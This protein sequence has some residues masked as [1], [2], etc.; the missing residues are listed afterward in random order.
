MSHLTVR[1]NQEQVGT[2]SRGADG[3][4]RFQLLPSWLANPAR[5]VLGQTFEDEPSKVWVPKEPGHVPHW[6]ANLLPERDGLVRQVLCDAW[7]VDPT[8]DGALFRILGA[9]LPGAVTVAPSGDAGSVPEAP[10]T[11][12]PPNDRPEL[13]GLKFSLAGVQLKFSV[14]HRDGKIRLPGADEVGSYILKVAVSPTQVAANEAAMMTW[15]ASAGLDVAEVQLV[16]LP[17]LPGLERVLQGAEGRALLVRRFDR[18]GARR[19][20]QEDL[21]QVFNVAPGNKYGHTTFDR[22]ARVAA[23]LLGEPGA[24]DFTRR[25]AV[26]IAQGNADA[27]LKNWS[28]RYAD[29]SAA[30]WSPMYDQVSTVAWPSVD[31][32]MALKFAGTK[33]F[34]DVD[35]ARVATFAAQARLPAPAVATAM[36]ETIA[37]LAATWRDLPARAELP[38]AHDAALREHWA[39]VPL[40]RRHGPLPP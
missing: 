26:M 36:H 19:V 16:D 2:L 27:H 40:L 38:P 12:P 6:F 24:L 30:A 8:D 32:R 37:Q 1:L 13:D 23:T 20:H 33:H 21:A 5:G 14:V 9:D 22:V 31:R 18:D 10:P 39:H 3:R 7:E 25:L 29:P 15:A 17:T 28:L 35:D 11:D 34:G 4:W